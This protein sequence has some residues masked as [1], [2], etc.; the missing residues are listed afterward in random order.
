MNIT[1]VERTRDLGFEGD[2]VVVSSP[3]VPNPTQVGYAWQSNPAA[4]LFKGAGL[5]AEPF[6]TDYWAGKTEGV[7]P[8]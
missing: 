5:A 4:T 3:L 7:R 6:R 8:Y 1:A 2:T